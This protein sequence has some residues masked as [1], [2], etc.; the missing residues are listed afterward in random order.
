MIYAVTRAAQ[1]LDL[2]LQDRLGRP[3]NA[4]LGIGLVI[5][6]VR[7]LTEAPHKVLDMHRLLGSAL[8]I[9]MELALLLHQVGAL[10]HHIERRR[11]KRGAGPAGAADESAED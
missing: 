10:S 4:L 6:I 7:R 5:E 2:W 9:I 11:R 1:R 3:Y 8:V